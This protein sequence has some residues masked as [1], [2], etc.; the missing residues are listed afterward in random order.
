[1]KKSK[2]SI[3][4]SILLRI[5]LIGGIICLFCLPKLYDLLTNP[6]ISSFHDHNIYY[7]VAFYTCYILSLA[8][9]YEVLKIFSMIYKDTPFKKA[10]ERTL[11]IIAILFMIL[12]IIIIIKI[13]FIPTI[14]SIAVALVTFIASLS[15]YVLSQVFKVAIAYK[16]EIDY[17]I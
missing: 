3:I 16:K 9:I 7:Q 6:E 11:K 1:M 17:T 5:M 13:I 15:F 10:T 14:L 8:I 4:I 2:I 12:S